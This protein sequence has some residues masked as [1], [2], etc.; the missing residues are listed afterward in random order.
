MTNQWQ[1]TPAPSPLLLPLSVGMAVQQRTRYTALLAQ[2]HCS[3]S[4]H[5]AVNKFATF[6]SKITYTAGMADKDIVFHSNDSQLLQML[7]S[8]G[9]I[10]K[11]ASTCRKEKKPHN[12]ETPTT[13]HQFPTSK[14]AIL[15]CFRKPVLMEFSYCWGRHFFNTPDFVPTTCSS[16]CILPG[17]NK[18]GFFSKEGFFLNK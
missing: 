18:L 15:R 5:S 12:T 3:P 17:R 8:A 6:D 2:L 14:H 9:K 10:L 7:V 16:Y 4:N 11:H 1:A 13:H